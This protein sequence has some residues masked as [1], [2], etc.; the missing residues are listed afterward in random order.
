MWCKA[1]RS[2]PGHGQKA[3]SKNT[4]TVSC[5]CVARFLQSVRAL[6]MQLPDGASYRK[7]K[8]T[9]TFPSCLLRIESTIPRSVKPLDN[10]VTGPI[11]FP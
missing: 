11:P 8:Q 6:R 3:V 7:A 1:C 9:H 4:I 2:G 10:S 5:H